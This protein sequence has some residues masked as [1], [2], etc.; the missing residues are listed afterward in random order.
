LV[1][2]NQRGGFNPLNRYISP[3]FSFENIGA[4]REIDLENKLISPE[5]QLRQEEQTRMFKHLPLKSILASDYLCQA[6]SSLTD[7]ITVDKFQEILSIAKNF[8]GNVTSF[9]GFE[10]HLRDATQRADWA[11]AV[12]G[13]GSDREVL[14]NL[15]KNGQLPQQYF[16]QPEW[17]HIAE[18]SE[19][20][21]DQT[22]LLQKHIK[23]FWLEFDMPDTPP[24]VFI[25]SVFFGPEKLS[26]GIASND[27][28]QYHWLLHS[29]LPLLRG[30]QLS[31]KIQHHILN[32]IKKIPA[33]ASLFQVGTMLSRSS[34]D[35][36]LYIN[37]IDPKDIIPYL[38]SLGWSD[39]G[40]FQSLIDDLQ[41]K[42]DRFVL[43]FDVN[44]TGIG[45]RLGIECSFASNQ[46]HQETR[47]KE[48][49]DYL[50]EKG[51]CLPE[52]R[53]A[54]L[55]YPGVEHTDISSSVMKPLTSASRHL[56]DLLAG[57]LVR[58]I[59]HIKIVYYPGRALEAKAYPAV[60]LFEQQ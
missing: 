18:F 54:L 34:N 9:L 27:P 14:V 11:F 58:Y 19:A 12:S 3:S 50:T 52:K 44:E 8:P 57:M 2:S 21:A 32:C 38:K 53:D 51:M 10:I 59:S 42:A 17:R 31:K 6:E 40:E 1:A 7:L 30:Q 37:R 41:N 45:F 33:T 49:F 20:W 5:F 46:Y 15:M 35:V 13:D 60:R 55:G 39:T 22:S 36:R 28:S 24:T 47:W 56:D 29:A 43:S 16:Q 4:V 25:P 48:L 26:E 23:C